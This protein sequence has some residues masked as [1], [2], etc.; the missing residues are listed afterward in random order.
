MPKKPTIEGRES[1]QKNLSMDM[2][3]SRLEE[4]RDSSQNYITRDAVNVQAKKR[5]RFERIQKMRQ[6][7]TS[8]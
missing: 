1:R 3:G 6:S 7:S 5:Q 8:Q 4:K 2:D